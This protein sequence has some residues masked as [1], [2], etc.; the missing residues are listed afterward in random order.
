[1]RALIA[2]IEPEKVVGWCADS[3]FCI[4]YFQRT[5][6]STF[7][8]CILNSHEGHTMCKSMVDIE[9]VAD[10]IRQGKKEERKIP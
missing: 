1:M 9:S 3:D 2:K 8:T 4:L 5:A 6:C 7:Q 10:K